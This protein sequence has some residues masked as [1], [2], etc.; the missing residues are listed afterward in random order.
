MHI[1]KN[2]VAV[3]AGGLIGMIVNMGLIMIGSNIISLPAGVDPMDEESLRNG[4]HLF[5]FRHFIFPF[6]AHAGGTLVG[7][8]SA[9]R[10]SVSHHLIFALVIGVFFQ[11]GGI[12]MGRIMNFE[13]LWYN[14]IDLIVCYL[15]MGWLGWKLSKQPQQ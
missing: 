4:L 11:M 2:I 14:S 10:I 1:V 13:P 7:A 8:F 5:E 3:I 6:L 12:A 15:P 9:S